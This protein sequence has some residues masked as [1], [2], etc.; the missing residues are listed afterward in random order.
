MDRKTG[1]SRRGDDSSRGARPDGGFGDEG[2][3]RVGRPDEGTT[4]APS[5]GTGVPVGEE[6]SI[7]EGEESRRGMTASDRE[8]TGAG[9]E[10]AEGMH[11]AK[12]GRSPEERSG[13]ERARGEPGRGEGAGLS[14]SEPL[15]HRETEHKSGYGGEQGEPKTSSD[16]R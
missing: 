12:G 6:G 5:S 16:Q 10:A 14:G 2:G 13:V 4:A 8:S 11:S 7:L 3:T 9:A 15:R 1:G